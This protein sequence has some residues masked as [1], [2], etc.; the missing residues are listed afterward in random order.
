MGCSTC[1]NITLP[2]SNIPGPNGADGATGAAGTSVSSAS[3]NSTTGI[4]TLT[5][6]DGSTVVASGSL[7]GPTGAAGSPQIYRTSVSTI[8]DGATFTIP[9]SSLTTAGFAMATVHDFSYEVYQYSEIATK[10]A[11]SVAIS[12]S[13]DARVG[14][15]VSAMTVD[16]ISGSITITF[17]KAGGYTVIF[18]GV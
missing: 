14:N 6:S 7:I 18:L 4:L 17:K 16:L 5:L 2:D 1:N 11:P 12:P 15:K 10:G 13:I 9:Q 8:V 3:V